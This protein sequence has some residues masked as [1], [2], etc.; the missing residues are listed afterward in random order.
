MRG[1]LMV[2]AAT[3][4]LF[5]LS[6]VASVHAAVGYVTPP[7]VGGKVSPAG[8]M[9]TFTEAAVLGIAIVAAI[10]VTALIRIKKR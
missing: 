9:F 5:V 2:L 1:K 4:A 7:A 6:I 10:V 8:S 3:A